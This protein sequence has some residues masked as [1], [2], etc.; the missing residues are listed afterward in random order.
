MLIMTI[1]VGKW[2]LINRKDCMIKGAGN[3]K[4][5][6]IGSLDLCE[7]ENLSNKRCVNFFTIC[8]TYCLLRLESI[9][10]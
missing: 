6:A 9:Y 4:T 2:S 8:I 10:Y 7:N 3:K 1:L 5:L